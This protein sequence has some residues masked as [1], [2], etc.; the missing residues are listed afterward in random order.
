[1]SIW[2]KG[3]AMLVAHGITPWCPTARFAPAG[4]PKPLPASISGEP[5]DAILVP[6]PCCRQ[7]CPRQAVAGPAC[8]ALPS[9]RCSELNTSHP[10]NLSASPASVSLANPP[11]AGCAIPVTACSGCRTTDELASVDRIATCAA[12]QAVC[13]LKSQASVACSAQSA[14]HSSNR[15]YKP[16]LSPPLS[17][18]PPPSAT[19]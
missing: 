12:S 16:Y 14:P 8:F 19:V 10:E 9:C 11:P 13:V 18:W 17:S 7:R 4:H 1:M 15:A 5:K 2:P 3:C 6:L